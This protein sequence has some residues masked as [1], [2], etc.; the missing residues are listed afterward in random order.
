M[1]Y[2]ADVTQRLILLIAPPPATLR[3]QDAADLEM[4][5]AALRWRERAELT[6]PD[7]FS[8]LS[9]NRWHV[10]LRQFLD[11]DASAAKKREAAELEYLVKLL[12]RDRTRR[13]G[14]DRRWADILGR[15]IRDDYDVRTGRP[16]QG[17]RDR[18][19]SQH[20]W[21]LRRIYVNLGEDDCAENVARVHADT[22]GK[23]SASRIKRIVKTGEN[24]KAAIEWI[25]EQLKG[26]GDRAP[27]VAERALL[28]TFE[29]TAAD[30]KVLAALFG[31]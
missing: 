24:R 9:G 31:Q 19:L 29:P 13:H 30:Q 1:S 25:D 11:E 28:A 3:D 12:A 26:L 7:E 5:V 17:V 8:L 22:G 6:G 21:L 2:H 18:L 4:L 16:K 15:F 20:Y 27:D 14:T 23:L 10:V